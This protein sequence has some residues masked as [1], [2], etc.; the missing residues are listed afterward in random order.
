MHTSAKFEGRAKKKM[1]VSPVMTMGDVRRLP[2][3]W[4]LVP[5]GCWVPIA[6]NCWRSLDKSSS[7]KSNRFWDSK[8]RTVALH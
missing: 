4:R 1:V 2:S 7:A 3:R 8:P 6:S 5:L